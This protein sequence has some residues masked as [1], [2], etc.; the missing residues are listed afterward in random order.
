MGKF[1]QYTERENK[2]S[3][4]LF[5][6]IILA[7]I[8]NYLF[9]MFISRMLGPANYGAFNSLQALFLIFFLPAETIRL[10]ITKYVSNL[11]VSEN[12]GEINHL[13]RQSFF[14]LFAVGLLGA[15]VIVI[16]SPGIARFLKLDDFKPVWVVALLIPLILTAPVGFGL[17]QGLQR[18][19]VLG[20]STFVATIFRLISGVLFVWA[21]WGISGALGG[22][23]TQN[24][25][26][27]LI[28]FWVTRSL[29]KEE[30]LIKQTSRQDIYTY[31]IPVAIA[32]SSLAVLTNIDMLLV[33]HYFT[34][35]EAG[36]YSAASLLGKAVVFLAGGV[37][38]IMFPKV[39][40]LDAQKKQT[41]LLLKKSLVYSI[42]IALTS[43]L[44][45]T[46]APNLLIKILFGKKYISAAP[47]LLID[48]GYA[49]IP[50][51]LLNVIVNYNLAIHRW[52]FL[53]FLVGGTIVHC[54]L[55]TVFHRS[56]QQVILVIGVSGLVNFLLLGLLTYGE[57]NAHSAAGV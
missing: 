50:L 21:G 47:A 22:L 4:I 3:V 57:K 23:L 38:L 5:L 30:R 25:F 54:L 48:F 44:I 36:F 16:L 52:K 19:V 24:I 12:L 40:E 8:V 55:L 45:F 31:F 33:K 43:A 49:M 2:E 17:L 9:Y 53:Y 39:S 10:V 26:T 14:R 28:I 56:L 35:E 20:M 41:F 11:K 34:A 13:I 51:I 7:N 18:F 37:I 46:A 42:I 27:L 32:L 15:M 1:S 6:G 29:F